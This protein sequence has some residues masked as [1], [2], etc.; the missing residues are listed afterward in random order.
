VYNLEA[1]HTPDDETS[2]GAAVAL[3]MVTD[4]DTSQQ[5]FGALEE[6]AWRL[7]VPALD[8][9]AYVMWRGELPS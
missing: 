8:V 2:M 5:A 1:P 3:L 4:Y 6:S 7:G 9:A